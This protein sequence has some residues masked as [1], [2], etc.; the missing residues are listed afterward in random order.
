MRVHFCRFIN[1]KFLKN[2]NSFLSTGWIACYF[3]AQCQCTDLIAHSAKNQSMACEVFRICL[4]VPSNVGK[5][6]RHL[7][8]G[9]PVVP[10]GIEVMNGSRAA[11]TDFIGD[12]WNRCVFILF[13]RRF[14]LF[15]GDKTGK[16]RLY[17][18]GMIELKHREP[19]F[20]FLTLL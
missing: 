12:V 6:V 18:N 9:P 17:G 20:H 4:T 13:C 14:Y 3:P 8:I 10:F 2:L 16:L 1:K 7:W 5:P 11:G 19:P 15:F